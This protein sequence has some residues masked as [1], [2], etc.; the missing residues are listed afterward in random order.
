[1]LKKAVSVVIPA[2]SGIFA[3]YAF[4]LR[5]ADTVPAQYTDAEFWR[6]INDFSEPGARILAFGTKHQSGWQELMNVP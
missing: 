6:F 3:F 4:C 5:A 2:L 1:M